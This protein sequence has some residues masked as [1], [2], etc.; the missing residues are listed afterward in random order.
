MDLGLAH[1]L[2]SKLHLVG[3]FGEAFG[4]EFRSLS[5]EMVLCSFCSS[6]LMLHR[7]QGQCCV[8]ALGSYGGCYRSVVLKIRLALPLSAVARACGS[9]EFLIY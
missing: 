2:C 9:V 5:G 8:P 1:D 6:S 3:C 7:C 4:W